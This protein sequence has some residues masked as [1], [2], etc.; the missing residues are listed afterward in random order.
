M[1]DLDKL[2]ER[3]DRLLDHLEK[4]LPIKQPEPDW[5]TA[6]A[7]RWRRQGNA[8]YIQ[9]ITH[10]HRI[11]LDALCGIDDQKQRIDQNTQQFVQGFSANN[12]LLTG[13]RGTGK[14]SLIKAL[15]NKY[16]GDGLRL[17]E[18]EKHH[19]VDLHD[20]VE[21]IYQRPERFI[22][23][24]DDLSFETDEPGYKALKVVLDGSIATVS[25]NVVIYATSN[26]RH[27][28][29]EFM[30]DNLDTRHIGEEVHPSEAIEEKISLSERFGLWVSFYPF[31]QDQYLEIVRYWLAYFGIQEMTV[32]ARTE[33]LQWAIERG[34]RSGRIAWQF[35]RDLAGRQQSAGDHS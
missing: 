33:A 10:P 25:D 1:N 26:R 9:S 32:L 2:C 5:Q 15:L 7:F 34:S 11:A 31:N 18:V 20:I 21:R 6:I 29:P 3:A 27:M 22:L 19:L 12:V 14:S 13:A 17:I 4:F 24:C 16:A 23:F 35:A 8:G 30:R 28:V